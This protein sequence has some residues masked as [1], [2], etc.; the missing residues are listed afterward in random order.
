MLWRGIHITG[1]MTCGTGARYQV[2][3]IEMELAKKD[4]SS[5]ARASSSIPFLFIFSDD[6]YWCW[7]CRMRRH[8]VPYG[9]SSY[10]WSTAAFEIFSPSTYL[11]PCDEQQ[12]CSLV[13][14]YNILP[15]VFFVKKALSNKIGTQFLQESVRFNGNYKRIVL[16]VYATQKKYGGKLLLNGP[17]VTFW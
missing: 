6:A 12:G 13:H 4:I 11:N 16:L 1:H 9:Q 2:L 14:R 5:L 15:S 8:L 10:N 3:C 7:Y 17:L